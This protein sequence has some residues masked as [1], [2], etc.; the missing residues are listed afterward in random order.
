V[1]PAPENINVTRVKDLQ[2]EIDSLKDEKRT[3][4]DLSQQTKEQFI[5]ANAEIERLSTVLEETTTKFNALNLN[6][7]E[8]LEVD[9]KRRAELNALQSAHASLQHQQSDAS[10]AKTVEEEDVRQLNIQVAKE[11]EKAD[12]AMKRI[13]ELEHVLEETEH[14]LE[15]TK[16][17]LEEFSDRVASPPPGSPPQT[18]KDGRVEFQ[19]LQ[20]Q[21]LQ[22]A[23]Q[24][25]LRE[26]ARLQ[27]ELE[28]QQEQNK[29]ITR[30]LQTTSQNSQREISRMQ[31]ELE[32]QQ[33][34][35]K[36]NS[37]R[38][39]LCLQEDNTKL[40][41]TVAKLLSR[42]LDGRRRYRKRTVVKLVT[43]NNRYDVV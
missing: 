38:E 23:N 12:N 6:I 20:I 3:L 25:S 34:E 11:Q 15:E 37:T 32:V 27:S 33:K 1:P 7:S 30:E 8:L 17:E 41:N 10:N 40:R 22:V 21:E 24:N 35:S 39:L 43:V 14:E 18:F 28:V 29:R 5:Q 19:E 16:Q 4:K 2:I 13:L 36:S 42:R 31:S 9:R 26:I